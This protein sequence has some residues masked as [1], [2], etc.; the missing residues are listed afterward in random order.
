[1]ALALATNQSVPSAA[2]RLAVLGLVAGI[3]FAPDFATAGCLRGRPILGGSV[4]TAFPHCLLV[5]EPPCVFVGETQNLQ[6]HQL[7]P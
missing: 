5:A 7:A 1:M 4:V 2:T 3:V 6:R